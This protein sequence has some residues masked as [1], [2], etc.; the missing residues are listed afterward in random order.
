MGVSEACY[1]PAALAK[2]AEHHGA[3]TRSL[4]VGIH[5]SGLYAGMILGG[6]AGGWAGQ[7]DGW[8]LPFVVLGT[9]GIVY[10]AAVFRFFLRNP[11]APP[12]SP[13]TPHQFGPAGIGLWP[14]P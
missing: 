2:I 13:K 14:L 1:L 8:R 6:A 10:F 9:I 12:R 7:K 5:Q 3:R 4:A 11:A